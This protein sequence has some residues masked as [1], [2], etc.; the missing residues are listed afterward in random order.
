MVKPG[1]TTPPLIQGVKTAQETNTDN[2]TDFDIVVYSES[3]QTTEIYADIPATPDS[4][5]N[6]RAAWTSFLSL[7]Q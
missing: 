5:W 3:V 4:S 2:I 7:S 6:W 1:E